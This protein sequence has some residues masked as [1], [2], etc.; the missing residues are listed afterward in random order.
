MEGF[1]LRYS[2]HTS[3]KYIYVDV[4]R[5]SLDE[6]GT[7]DMEHL[8]WSSAFS[9]FRQVVALGERTVVEVGY[10]FAETYQFSDTVRLI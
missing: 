2:L 5:F 1:S 6:A 4:T 7:S 10:L 3:W 9:P 8:I